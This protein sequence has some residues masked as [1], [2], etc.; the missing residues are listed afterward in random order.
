MKKNILIISIC[1]LSIS[2][3]WLLKFSYKENEIFSEVIEEEIIEDNTPVINV[4]ED[5]LVFYDTDDFNILNYVEINNE[6]GNYTV[7]I[8]NEEK[9]KEP[10]EKVIE[11]QAVD[12]EGNTNSAFITV[13]IASNEEWNDYVNENTYNYRYRRLVNDDL[14]EKKGYADR[15]AFNLALN[16]IGMKGSCNEVAQSFIDAYF[17]EGYDILLGTYSISMDEAKPGDIIYYTNGGIGQQHYA[18]Y[19][20]GASA[21]HGNVNGTTV[22]GNVYMA[23]GSTPQFRRLNGIE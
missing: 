23:H 1:V 16:F 18:T 15:D 10:G 6:N 7:S 21:L 8:K 5:Y 14:V 17:G 13:N 9:I 11:I 2:T 20:G 19:L 12:E 22:I 3:I 4:L